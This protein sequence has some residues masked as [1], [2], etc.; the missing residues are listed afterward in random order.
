MDDCSLRPLQ[1]RVGVQTRE[2]VNRRVYVIQAAGRH[3]D[4]RL[5]ILLRQTVS[6]ALVDKT[7]LDNYPFA[8]LRIQAEFHVDRLSILRLLASGANAFPQRHP[9]TPLQRQRGRQLTGCAV[10]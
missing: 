8:C 3:A 10:I 2:Q 9:M 1:H 4:W 6:H 5:T 7:P